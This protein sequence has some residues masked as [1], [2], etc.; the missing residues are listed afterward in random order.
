MK[1]LSP[2]LKILTCRAFSLV[3]VAMSL[4]IVAIA[5]LV[6]MALLP[7]G[8]QSTR[9]S[10]EETGA[11]NVISQIVADRR[12]TPAAE[13]SKIYG[14]PALTGNFTVPV[15]NTFG[16]ANLQQMQPAP[17]AGAQYR[18]ESILTSPAAGRSDP[19]LDY[20]KV[21]WPANAANGQSLE[22]IV[23]FPQP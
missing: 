23:S 7:V 21:S 18:V 1:M 10:L 12:A 14:L 3:E 6:V 4:G 8:V 13:V 19:Y 11:V 2:P 22:V 17:L 16:I 20:L 9:D 15:T 5:I